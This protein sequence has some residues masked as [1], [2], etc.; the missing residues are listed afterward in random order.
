MEPPKVENILPRPEC[1]TTN[2]NLQIYSEILAKQLEETEQRIKM[3]VNG[4]PQ[5]E[6]E[7]R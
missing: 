4:A 6:P 2:P 1:R 5:N 7:I 3:R